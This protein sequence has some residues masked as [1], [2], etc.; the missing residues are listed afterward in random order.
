MALDIYTPTDL[1]GVMYDPRQTVR[2]KHWLERFYPGS[3]MSEQEEIRFDK[4]DANREIAPFMLPNA[5][6]KPIFRGAGE[7]IETFKPAYTKPKD[8]VRP[9]QALALQPGE[10]SKR[11]ALQTPEA[12][13]NAKV[14]QIASMHRDAIER[15]WDYMGARSLI[16]GQMTINYLTDAGTPGHSVTIDFGR[17]P[18]HT[19]VKGGGAQWGDAGV[20][21][22]DDIQEWYDLAAAAEFGA[23]PT[24]V[25]MGAKAYKAFM[26]DTDVI[27][28]L[29][30][31]MRGNDSV[32]LDLGL[33]AKDPLNP[34]T[35]VGAI[36]AVK[37]W[38]VS[39]IGN[40]FKSGGATVDIIKSNEVLLASTAV[41]G[42][43]AFGAI[44]DAAA[45]IQPAEIFSKM[46]DNQDPSVRY[47][48]SQSAPL[49][50]PVNC[51]A[52]V[53]A[54]PVSL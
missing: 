10:L 23:A 37:V 22:W 1:Y 20:S 54:T 14:I 16:D 32:K 18:S 39:G 4:I 29:N 36:G 49:M 52:T 47:I 13:Y 41:D 45:D 35:Y 3:H 46:W 6:G 31:D 44:L 2:A 5:P 48:M 43:K 12:R 9:S 8:S 40:T 24:D 53:K 34:F 7:R 21:A 17:D 38:L 42:V 15:L 27:A 30:K 26:A 33:I 11:I 19:I 50:I 51:N 28:K 25:Y